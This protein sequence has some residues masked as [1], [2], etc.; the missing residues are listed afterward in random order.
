MLQARRLRGQV[1]VGAIERV[2]NVIVERHEI[3]RTRFGESEGEPYQIVEPRVWIPLEVE[4][5][6]GLAE[7]VQ[8]QAIEAALQRQSHK[9]FDLNEGP[10]L[11]T[12]ILKLGPRDHILHWTSHHIVSDGW[13]T[14]VFAEEFSILY[15][16][17]CEGREANL[18]ELPAQYVD[19]ALWQR[20]RL[21]EGEY[22]RLLAYWREQLRDLPVLEL[23][24]DRPRESSPNFAGGSLTLRLPDSL[25]KELRSLGVGE[26]ASMPMVLLAAFTLLL[27]RLS[28][29][30]DVAVGFPIAGRTNF[31]SERLIGL[32]VN[33]LVFRARLVSSFTFRQLLAEVRQT[34][35]DAYAH[36]TVPFEKL[37]EVLNPER[38]LNRHPL[39]E[40]LFN[41]VTVAGTVW[42]L[43]G[44]S[45]EHFR[46]EAVQAKFPITL[47]LEESSGGMVLRVAYQV[48]LFFAA[49]IA[50]IL[51][52]FHQLLEQVAE[53]PDRPIFSY[54]LVTNDAQRLLPDPTMPLCEPEHVSAPREFLSV[55]ER[56][57][58]QTALCQRGKRMNYQQLATSATRIATLLRSRGVQPGD[59]V[60]IS[61][62]RCF[63]LIS[64]I[65]GV[66]LARGVLLL[67]DSTLPSA[68]RDAMLQVACGKHWL[69]VGDPD[70][71]CDM[72]RDLLFLADN[73][74]FTRGKVEGCAQQQSPERNKPR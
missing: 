39:F 6:S 25:C 35:L 24:I 16:S 45:V 67:L 47:Y 53:G 34:S 55:A 44:L 40:V 36:Q 58:Q 46:P 29:Q 27:G 48:A 60:A 59:V 12:G 49:R 18:P 68:R 62:P 50:H 11:R 21:D 52:Q 65:M 4:D 5:F 3:L 19:Y 73:F 8:Q 37:V 74:D 43:P 63:G 7:D 70:A 42:N 41:Y 72:E 17:F 28:G 10:L 30:E 38:V 15:A 32:F 33:T 71:E 26:G 57:P 56:H 64:G 13:S 22:E 9:R 51:A 61:G 14:R 31:E 23:P 2:I 20:R 69:R 66:L 54:S 1:D